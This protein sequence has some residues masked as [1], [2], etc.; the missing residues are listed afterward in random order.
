[1]ACQNMAPFAKEVWGTTGGFVD[2]K[3]LIC[4]GSGS[5][6]CYMITKSST[7]LVTKMIWKRVYAASAVSYTHLTLPTIY[8]V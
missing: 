2:G 3:P 4:G 5:D 8:S 7:T 1:M 6:E